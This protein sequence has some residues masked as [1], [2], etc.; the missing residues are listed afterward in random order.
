MHEKHVSMSD[1]S[2]QDFVDKTVSLAKLRS[3]KYD[4]LTPKGNRSRK[5][6]IFT[7]NEKYFS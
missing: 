6:C 2:T 5:Y 4:E 7:K 1:I 3:L